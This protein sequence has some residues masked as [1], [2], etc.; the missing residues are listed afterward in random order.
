MAGGRGRVEGA[1]EGCDLVVVELDDGRV[2]TDGGKEILHDVAH[3][4][5]GAGEDDDGV[6]RYQ[7]LDPVLRR[8]GPV[9]GEALHRRREECVTGR[10]WRVL[11]AGG[12]CLELYKSAD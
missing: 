3:T 6:L 1:R 12:S 9:D 5:G 11:R 7:P 8:L 4:A 2:D 10:E